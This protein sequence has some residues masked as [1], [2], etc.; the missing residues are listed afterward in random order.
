MIEMTD[1]PESPGKKVAMTAAE[2]MRK[3]RAKMSAEKIVETKR[4]NAEDQKALRQSW[5]SY[6]KAVQ[7]VKRALPVSPRKQRSIVKKLAVQ[8]GIETK[9]QPKTREVSDNEDEHLVVAFYEIP[10]E[11]LTMMK[12]HC[13][14]AKTQLRAMKFL[15]NNLSTEEA[16]MQVDYLENF[17]IRQQN[18]IMAAQWVSEGV[19]LYTCVITQNGSSTNYVVVSDDL[20]HDKFS[21]FC[22]NQLILEEHLK[23]NAHISTLHIC[24][25]GAPSQFKNKYI[26]YL[27]CEPKTVHPSLSSIIMTFLGQLMER[28]QLMVFVAQLN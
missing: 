4:K 16:V 23:N 17:A 6:R 11:W 20:Q 10:T 26:V 3:Y 27:V 14:I 21:V 22:C 25:D 2:R 15:K 9:K 28:V 24:S 13:F 12:H 1:L 7:R 8:Y 18:E 5:T 19:T